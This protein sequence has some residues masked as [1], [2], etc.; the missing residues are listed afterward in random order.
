MR[1]IQ[2]NKKVKYIQYKCIYAQEGD[3][4]QRQMQTHK[5]F[6]TAVC[7]VRRW[8]AGRYSNIKESILYT[9]AGG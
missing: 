7:V 9:E 6:I 1:L 3:T 2:T 4:Q 8:L 5:M